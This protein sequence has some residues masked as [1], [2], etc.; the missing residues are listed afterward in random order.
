MGPR[1]LFLASK[2]GYQTRVFVEAAERL[3]YRIQLATDRCHR[4]ADPWGVGA[5]AFDFDDPS[6]V[7]VEGFDGI[8]AA[9]DAPAYAASMIAAR[10][11][12]RYHPPDAV[13][14]SRNKYEARQRF[15]LKGAV[16]SISNQACVSSLP[17]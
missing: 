10:H 11:G 9:G 13:A 3:G 14:A 7:T 5:L 1:V 16:P 17:G 2:I 12:L 8:L 15:V 6:A 4:L